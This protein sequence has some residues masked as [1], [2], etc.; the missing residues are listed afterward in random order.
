VAALVLYLLPASPLRIEPAEAQA[1]VE[2]MRRSM[3]GEL[4]RL[5]RSASDA[6]DRERL[7]KERTE[8]EGKRFRVESE[9]D[10][11]VVNGGLPWLA[12]YLWADALSGPAVNLFLLASGVGLVLCKTWGRTLAL[13]TSWFKLARLLLLNGLLVLIVIPH[14]SRAADQFARSEAGEAVVGYAMSQQGLSRGGGANG[15]KLT[16]GE[17]VQVMGRMGYAY[18]ATFLSLGAIY[19][20][21]VLIVLSRP[22]ARAACMPRATAGEGST[23]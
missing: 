15:P 17:A 16:P 7:H 20:V 1:A 23:Q 12:R 14:L 22:G 3:V 19:P 4:A 11:R 5:E 2:E 6:A 18:A 8:L 13:W 21:V 10:F 9:V